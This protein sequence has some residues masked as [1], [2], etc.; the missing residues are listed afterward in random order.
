MVH[1]QK[2]RWKV[3]IEVWGLRSPLEENG[4]CQI[5]EDILGLDAKQEAALCPLTHRWGG[6]PWKGNRVCDSGACKWF[7]WKQTTQGDPT[8]MS[9][10]MPHE[11]PA[12]NSHAPH[13]NGS[14]VFSSSANQ[15]LWVMLW[16]L[17][18]VLSCLFAA[19]QKEGRWKMKLSIWVSLQTGS[20]VISDRETSINLSVDGHQ[21]M[22]YSYREFMWPISTMCRYSWI[23]G[24]GSKVNT[25]LVIFVPS[26]SLESQGCRFF[27]LL[28]PCEGE[29]FSLH[30]QCCL[31]KEKE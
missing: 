2:K 8:Q 31:F 30:P 24:H 6:N 9:A 27:S 10:L 18:S 28:P 29:A 22:D 17:T 7:S 14:P 12:S 5:R 11:F 15:T 13:T 20:T 23:W 21:E 16:P 1:S 19:T 25:H 4:I 3:A 26:L